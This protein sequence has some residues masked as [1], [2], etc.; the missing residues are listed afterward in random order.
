MNHSERL[1]ADFC[2]SNHIACDRVPTGPG[3]IVDFE[4]T[5]SGSRIAVEIEA[6][7]KMV[8]WNPDGC[9]T[10]TPGAHVRR[11]IEEARKQIQE[12]AA[13]GRPTILLIY[14]AVDPKQQFGTERHDFLAAMYGDLTWQFDAHG[15]SGLFH[16][17]SS[18]FRE[19]MNTS[20]SAV[21]HLRHT[22]SGA[23]V[24]LYENAHAEKKLSYAT[25]PSCITFNQI[26]V[27]S[28][29]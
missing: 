22:G 14:N 29:A 9:S 8:G 11:K 1:F 18:A 3:K 7:E 25:L 13:S 27:E 19:K 6:L 12:A 2:S 10:R 4:I 23:T 20:F 26:Q 24:H 17:R 5:I 28:A 15:V 21:G 16:G